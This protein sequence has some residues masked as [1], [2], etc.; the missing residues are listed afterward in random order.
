MLQKRMRRITGTMMTGA[1]AY[2][3]SVHA[4]RNTQATGKVP[5]GGSRK[6]MASK[7]WAARKKLRSNVDPQRPHVKAASEYAP[8]G[9]TP[10]GRAMSAVRRK[11]KSIQNRRTGS[12]RKAR[13]SV[14]AMLKPI[15][16]SR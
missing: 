10:T 15:I 8:Y 5:V 7:I 13:K 3:V 2:H 14:A 12:Y 6:K 1:P 11:K 16:V 9:K 4:G